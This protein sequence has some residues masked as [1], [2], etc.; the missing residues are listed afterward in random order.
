MR[1][2]SESRFLRRWA[3]L[4]LTKSN[5]RAAHRGNAAAA[6]HV[7]ARIACT[8]EWSSEHAQAVTDVCC[9]CCAVVADV[10]RSRLTQ[11]PQPCTL[12]ALTRSVHASHSLP[13]A[14]LEASKG[15]SDVLLS[16]CALLCIP[17]HSRRSSA[18]T[19]ERGRSRAATARTDATT[20]L[21]STN[22][23][24][25]RAPPL[26]H[27]S[28]LLLPPPLRLSRCSDVRLAASIS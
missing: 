18:V 9:R 23:S 26:L 16:A 15:C 4:C 1:S 27:Q 5:C 10:S 28:P 21:G 2:G 25:A 22:S 11:A 13:P 7:S 6:G 12:T 17:L 3:C 19:A 14:Q 24:T 20:A 8:L